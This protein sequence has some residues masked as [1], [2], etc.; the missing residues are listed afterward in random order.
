MFKNVALTSYGENDRLQAP[1]FA[2]VEL[3]LG[4]C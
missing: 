3:V 2:L 4:I 1:D